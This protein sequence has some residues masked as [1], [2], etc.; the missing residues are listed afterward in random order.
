MD[1]KGQ[2]HLGIKRSLQTDLFL[3]VSVISAR[4]QAA[5]QMYSSVE[6]TWSILKVFRQIYSELLMHQ[7]TLL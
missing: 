2:L 5:M 6:A 3:E 7:R 4:R 1:G